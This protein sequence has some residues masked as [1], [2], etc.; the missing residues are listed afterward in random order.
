ML[1]SGMTSL[2]DLANLFAVY[3][4]FYV[5]QTCIILD[6][7]CSAKRDDEVKFYYALDWEK[8]SKNRLCCIQGWE[9]LQGSISHMFSHAITLEILNQTPDEQMCDY[10]AF[11]KRAC[12]SDDV[13]VRIADEV[14]KAERIY[15]SYVGDYKEFDKIPFQQGVM[16]FYW[17]MSATTLLQILSWIF[18]RKQMQNMYME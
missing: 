12:E 4:F 14:E 17:W 16:V 11:G 7:F 10:I 9:K 18:Y 5:S 6:R 8:V 13:D 3:Y 1:E 15:C 2:E